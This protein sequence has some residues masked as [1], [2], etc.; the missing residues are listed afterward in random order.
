MGLVGQVLI[1]NYLISFC[2]RVPLWLAQVEVLQSKLSF[3]VQLD[4]AS[5]TPHSDDN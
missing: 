2:M 3:H 1:L 5:Q 4:P